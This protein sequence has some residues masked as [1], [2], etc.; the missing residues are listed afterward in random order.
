MSYS[1]DGAAKA[2]FRHTSWLFGS[3]QILG[4]VRARIE[5]L[6]NWEV[7]VL[8][9]DPSTKLLGLDSIV[10]RVI[11]EYIDT[12]ANIPIQAP[13]N[14]ELSYSAADG[15]SGAGIVIGA[16]APGSTTFTQG[17]NQGGFLSAQVFDQVGPET[18]T[19]TA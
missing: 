12:A 7:Q 19:I 2:L 11:L 18:F 5:R 14:I 16:C 6:V 10:S 3:S 4:K 1:V 8:D 13:D 9:G 15:T 17:R